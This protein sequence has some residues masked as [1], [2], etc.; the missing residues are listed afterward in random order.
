MNIEQIRKAAEERSP[1]LSDPSCTKIH[2]SAS[3]GD[4]NADSVYNLIQSAINREGIPASV[5]RT[6]SFGCYDRE[7][8]VNIQKPGSDPLVFAN[9]LPDA[10]TDL[11]GYFAGRVP[12]TP[13]L[14]GIPGLRLQKRIAL[15][16]CGW[17][18]PD[19]IRQYILR[20]HGYTGL[21]R[22]LKMDRPEL[23]ETRIPS[24]LKGRMD[25]AC[26]PPEAWGQFVEPSNAGA[27]MI[28]SGLDR[29]SGSTTARLLLESDPHSVLEG[30][31]IGAY[32]AGIRRCF[33]VV[34][35]N[36]G[37]S[38]RLQK[39]LDQM[40]ECTLLGSNVLDSRFRAEIEIKEF[41]AAMTSGHRMELF[42]CIEERQPLPHIIPGYDRSHEFIGTPSLIVNPESMSALSA[43][44]CN[45]D[46]FG[47]TR[48]V[49]LAGRLLRRCTIEIPS[50]TTIRSII[51]QFA[52]EGDNGR[53][54][55][56]ARVGGPACVFISPDDLDLP[57]G[58]CFPDAS[59]R[60]NY[61]GIIEVLDADSDIVDRTRD[62]MA[63][64][65]A[66]SCG[67]C[68]FC[69]EGCLQMLTILEDISVKGTLH[70]LELLTELGENMKSACLCSFGRTAPDP[71]L[72]G[73]KLFRHEYEERVAGSLP[74]DQGLKSSTPDP[75]T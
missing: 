40:K 33:I 64:I 67:K 11:V 5:V 25:P 7:P 69:R 59:S 42:R 54:I 3:A 15:R 14:A 18:D 29:D 17:I 57:V 21:S 10:F 1:L 61:C 38:Q 49:T 23:I 20:G 65:Q 74:P 71:V 70:D 43:L 28:C 19:D 36:T 2:V 62:I 44:L 31:L 45:E 53:A 73:M 60:H 13:G 39:A 9:V 32:A 68:V 22:A 30:M 16:N 55:K 27:S 51:E 48:V 41:S 72:S 4:T 52:S 66:Q 58:S 46:A 37:E 34:A 12:V 75:R 8:I 24:A 63:C 6:G 26:S 35:D 50:E 56:A 47:E